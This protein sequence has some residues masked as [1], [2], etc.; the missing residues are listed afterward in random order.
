MREI[1]RSTISKMPPLTTTHR[2]MTW[3][4]MCPADGSATAVQRTI[5]I[6][7]SLTFFIL[8]VSCFSASLAFFLIF[9]ST[10]FDGA[11]FAFMIA[12]GQ[13]GLIYFML[14]AI[15]MR[16]KIGCTFARLSTIY[17]SSKYN[18]FV[19][20]HEYLNFLKIF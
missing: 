6:A 8:N 14:A 10:D 4:S 11:M 20:Y 16:Y 3:L 18:V 13:F 7:H 12:I 9:Y 1:I 2:W 19:E 5:Y 15:L 17:D